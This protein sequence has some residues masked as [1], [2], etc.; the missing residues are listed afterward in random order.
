VVRGISFDI[1]PGEAVGFVGESGCGKSVTARAMMRL[2]PE[3]SSLQLGG[4]MTTA[5]RT[6]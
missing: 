2:A 3:G 5:G 4:T 6:C 1:A